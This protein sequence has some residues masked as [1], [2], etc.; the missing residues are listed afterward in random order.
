MN[1]S[2]DWGIPCLLLALPTLLFLRARWHYS[3]IP[4]LL[5]SEPGAPLPDCRVVIPARDEDAVIARAVASFSKDTVIVVDDASTDKTAEVARQ[6]GAGVI[7]APPPSRGAFGKPNACQAGAQVLESKW[8]L[9]ADADTAYSPGLLTAVV[10]AAEG[11]KIDF[12]SIH[13]PV[14]GV[15]GPYAEALYYSAVSPLARPLAAFRGKCVLV[16]R[17]PYEFVGGHGSVLR[18]FTEDA[19]L[20]A[21]AQ[22]HR[23]R[24]GTVRAG[25][26]A[27]GHFHR[28]GIAAGIK[29]QMFR[30]LDASPMLLL[31][32]LLHATAAA[33]WLPCVVSLWWQGFQWWATA[34][35][36][37]PWLWMAGWYRGAA[38]LLA[39][40]SFYAVLPMVWAPVLP[41]LTGKVPQWK[42]RI[43]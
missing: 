11:S 5:P 20:A 31:A 42:G 43:R 21:S 24:F 15:L 37:L 19:H 29:R 26:L 36:L 12:L 17:E 13:V 34:A 1:W 33:L 10:Q 9:F 3:Q 30:A 32:T 6:A 25:R 14:Y 41:L 4:V 23:M 38:L 28:D 18:Y 16:R 35:L 27:E 40:F 39:P 7:S 22:R 2:N 8:I